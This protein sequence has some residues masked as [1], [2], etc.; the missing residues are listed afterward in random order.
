MMFPA[1]RRAAFE[2]KIFRVPESGCWLWMGA[3]TSKGYG[4][5]RINRRSEIA[6]RIS[7]ENRYG[8]ISDGLSVLH[9]CDVR[10]C[11]N[12]AHLFLGT[13][14]ENISDMVSKGR[15]AK[16]ERMGNARLVAS[17]IH[18]MRSL[19]KSGL[20]YAKVGKRV[21]ISRS[22]AYAILRGFCWTHVKEKFDEPRND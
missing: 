11:V 14:Q 6:H 7:W 5:V 12:P 13:Q 17:D 18:E 8:Q 2:A 15:N 22:H 3:L 19:R 16:G 9:R 20:S 21:G 4:S 1:T 10:C